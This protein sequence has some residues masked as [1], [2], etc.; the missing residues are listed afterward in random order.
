MVGTLNKDA[1]DFEESDAKLCFRRIPVSR[2]IRLDCLSKEVDKGTLRNY[3][4]G[5]P[6]FP[7]VP[8]VETVEISKDLHCNSAIV[9]LRTT[10]GTIS[11][12]NFIFFWANFLVFRRRPY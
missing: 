6:T 12:V 3:L 9:T 4:F 7:P 11:V 10:A 2:S 1:S 5:L 8:L